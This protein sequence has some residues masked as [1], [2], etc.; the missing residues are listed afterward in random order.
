[1]VIDI[2]TR[3]EITDETVK[4]ITTPGQAGKIGLIGAF[5]NI[6]KTVY[7]FE[8]LDQLRNKHGIV[9]NSGSEVNFNGAL[10]A[11]RLFMDGVDNCAGAETVTTVNITQ[12]NKLSNDDVS[13]KVVSGADLETTK[14][15]NIAATHLTYNSLR[16]AL[17]RLA[18][19]DVDKIFIS[20]SIYNAIPQ[21]GDTLYNSNTP[22]KET[23]S[24]NDVFDLIEYFQ[25]KVYSSQKPAPVCYY[26]DKVPTSTNSNN[27]TTEKAGIKT[28]Q[29]VT[30]E[31]V[32]QAEYIRDNDA[33]NLATC[34]IYFQE[35]YINGEAATRMESAA[36]MLAWTASLPVGTSLTNK[37]VP[38]ITGIVGEELYFG[39]LDDGFKL[40]NAGIQ[41]VRPLN[42]RAGTYCIK[43]SIQPN[44][45]DIAHITAVAYLLKQYNF[46]DTL[47]ELNYELPI[48]VLKAQLEA[49][50]RDVMSVAPIIYEVIM[51]QEQ[52]LS[53]WKIYIPIKIRL[54]GII[55]VIKV[56]VSMEI[57]DESTGVEVTTTIEE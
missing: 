57:I 8:T 35:L 1:M 45:Y 43:N 38:G 24:I 12:D 2:N 14:A 17:V 50:N 16:N 10:A 4:E 46:V 20:D 54:H 26:W 52:I 41:V 27:T 23:G 55:D 25:T 13:I 48:Q 5:P 51:G 29:I 6:D 18:D 40:M 49:V 3:V 9:P 42:K 28:T 34:G 15:K 36:H 22:L 30:S 37:A 7:V 39:E 33:T 19:E 47:G 11:K 32:E 31:A 56:G 44:M 53:P 21:S